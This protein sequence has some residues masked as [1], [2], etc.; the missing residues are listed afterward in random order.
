VPAIPNYYWRYRMHLSLETL[1]A[2]D[3]FNQELRRLIE[4][5]GR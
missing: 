1:L 5:S 4:H 3:A 2:A